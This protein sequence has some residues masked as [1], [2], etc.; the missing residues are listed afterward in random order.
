MQ[1]ILIIINC[2]CAAA[3]VPKV[4]CFGMVVCH[5]FELCQQ[6]HQKRWCVCNYYCGCI[7]FPIQARSLQYLCCHYSLGNCSMTMG[8]GQKHQLKFHMVQLLQCNHELLQCSH[9]C[10]HELLQC[11]NDS[12]SVVV[13]K[14]DRCAVILVQSILQQFLHSALFTSIQINILKVY[15]N[16]PWGNAQTILQT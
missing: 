2:N 15:T 12:L 13:P 6:R 16:S 1:E 8:T 7:E 10:N 5:S 9:E 3:Q 4:A 14:I 11:H